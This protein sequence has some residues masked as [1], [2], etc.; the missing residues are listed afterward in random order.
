[1]PL[2]LVVGVA[3]SDAGFLAPDWAVDE[4]A[5]HELPLLCPLQ[6]F[7]GADVL[8]PESTCG[9]RRRR[10]EQGRDIFADVLARTLQ[11][12]GSVVIPAFVI[13]RT[14]AVLN[15]LAATASRTRRPPS[16]T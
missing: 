12:G 7:S 4:A 6:P 10:G 3:G 8:L 16:G 2:P 14:E 15:E 11:R 9:N 1:M 5:R 13:N